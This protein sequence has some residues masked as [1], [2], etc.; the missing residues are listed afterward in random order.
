MGDVLKGMTKSHSI[1]TRW[2]ACGHHVPNTMPRMMGAWLRSGAAGILDIYHSSRAYGGKHSRI[3]QEATDEENPQQDAEEGE[4]IGK[5]RL[6]P[7]GRQESV[8]RRLRG[9]AHARV[10]RR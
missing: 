4:H 8:E 5:D 9:G 2:I 3:E 1:S 6:S 7:R 10:D